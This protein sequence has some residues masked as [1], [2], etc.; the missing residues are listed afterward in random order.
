MLDRRSF[1]IGAGALLTASFVTKATA[2]SRDTGKPLVLPP[3][4]ASEQTLYIYNEQDWNESESAKWRVTLGEDNPI[5]PPTPTWREHLLRLGRRLDTDYEIKRVCVEHDLL[6][7][8]LDAKVDGY[9][10][11]DRWDHFTGPQAKAYHL[12]KNL[13]LG[14]SPGSR[15]QAGGRNDFRP[16][17]GR[18]RQLLLVC[19]TEGRSDGFFATGPAHRVELADQN[20][21]LS[22]SLDRVSRRA[23]QMTGVDVKRTLRTATV[24]VAVAAKATM[25]NVIGVAPCAAR[26]PQAWLRQRRALRR[27]RDERLDSTCTANA[28]QGRARAF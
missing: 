17:W 21:R 16:A 14:G 12:L 26:A 6:P 20:K 28:T 11:Q 5:P 23:S 25:R 24:D 1:L 22:E 3:A 19:T 7:E 13:D 15:S 9:W 18:S 8:K 27:F 4:R 10:W 2:F